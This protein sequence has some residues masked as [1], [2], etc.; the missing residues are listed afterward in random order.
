MKTRVEGAG[1]YYAVL[2]VVLAF[3]LTITI[4]SK[5]NVIYFQGIAEQKETSINWQAP[6]EIKRILV[7]EGESID[8]G[9]LLVELDSQEL[10]LKI[11]HIS[12]QLEQLKTQK[13]IDKATTRAKINQLKALKRARITENKNKIRQLEKQYDINQSLALGT[14]YTDRDDTTD[15]TINPIEL[16]IK[17]LRQGLTTAVAP[18]TIQIE[19]LQSMLAASENPLD[20]QIQRLSNELT[21][22]RLQK[23]KL[24]IYAPISGIIGSIYCKPGE[25]MNSFEP[26]LSLHTQNPSQVKGY[27]PENVSMLVSPGMEVN[28]RSVANSNHHVTGRVSG[29]GTRIVEFPVRLRKHVSD[30]LWGREVIIQLPQENNLLL[31]EKVLIEVM[32]KDTSPKY[33][34]SR[35]L[36]AKN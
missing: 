8:I 24:N 7:T 11:N 4:K 15:Q 21:L 5:S 27:I 2:V 3:I 31:G 29:L 32:G 33:V 17:S 36:A 1:L 34:E 13:G 30:F 28:I 19:L 14:S 10:R 12:Y 26:I 23:N 16:Q 9:Q 35:G 6:V 25:K 22:L 18:L 20:A